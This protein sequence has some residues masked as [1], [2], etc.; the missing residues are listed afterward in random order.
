MLDLE[1]MGYIGSILKAIENT[2]KLE[3]HS[4]LTHS[5]ACWTSPTTI[6]ATY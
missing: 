2:D 1:T 3:H 4:L 5:A 6:E